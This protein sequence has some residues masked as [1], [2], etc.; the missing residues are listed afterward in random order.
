MKKI[1]LAL[2]AAAVTLAIAPAAMATTIDINWKQN[3]TNKFEGGTTG[4]HYVTSW[5]SSNQTATGWEQ[6]E[7]GSY[8][9][10]DIAFTNL[11]WNPNQG[12]SGNQTHSI[13]QTG[14]P[15][16]DSSAAGTT[17]T[18]TVTDGGNLFAFDSIDIKND[19][20]SGNDSE[21]YTIKGYIGST[22]E[23]TLTCG[24]LGN[25]VCPKGTSYS[26]I[27]GEPLIDIN[28]LVISE[29][30]SSGSY[31]YMDYLDLTIFP[32]PEP[33]S[34][35]LLGTGLLGLGAL[36]RRKRTSKL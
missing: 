1:P 8:P 30:A 35:L 10:V 17:G 29:T 24:G 7:S 2:L 3:G 23:F 20:N 26:T 5:T 18:I 22:V 32:T 16:I 27:S 6:V 33:D 4:G 14:D 28:K 15:S 31:V 36:I 12:E 11:S 25:P 13:G 19:N 21:T 9:T 34:L